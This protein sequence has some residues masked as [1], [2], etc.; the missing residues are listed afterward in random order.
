[1]TLSK[2]TISDK[3]ADFWKKKNAGISEIKWILVLK[4]VFSQATYVSVFTY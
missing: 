1:M 2:G 3:N 4:S